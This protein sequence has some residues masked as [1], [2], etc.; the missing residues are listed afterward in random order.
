MSTQQNKENCI[1]TVMN[2]VNYIYT[3]NV[4]HWRC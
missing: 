2:R 3:A 4:L 1:Y